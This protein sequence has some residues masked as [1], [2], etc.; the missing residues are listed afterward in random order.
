MELTP[1]NSLY[2][3]LDCMSG[4]VYMI[5]IRHSEYKM[6]RFYIIFKQYIQY[7][8]YLLIILGILYLI[9]PHP[10]ILGLLIGACGSWLIHTSL[11]AIWQRLKRKML[12]IYQRA[13]FGDI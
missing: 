9:V 2:Y 8:L 7:Y 4:T 1:Y 11:K 10:F 6:S 13:I 5:G 12:Y 3:H